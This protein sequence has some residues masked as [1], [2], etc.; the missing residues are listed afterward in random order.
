MVAFFD[1]NSLSR[2]E[3]EEKKAQS[4]GSTNGHANGSVNGHTNGAVNG[5]ANGSSGPGSAFLQDKAVR[6]VYGPIPL[7]L[8]LDW[9]VCASYNEVAGCAKWMGGRIP[10]ME[11]ARSI[12][13]YVDSTRKLKAEKALGANIPAVNR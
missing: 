9:P 6:T 5:H 11:E 13:E 7:K 10:T 3:S 2:N 8:A 1:P 4:N 12:Y